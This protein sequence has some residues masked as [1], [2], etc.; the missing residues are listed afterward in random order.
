MRRWTLLV[1]LVAAALLAPAG[2]SAQPFPNQIPLPNGFAPEGIAIGRGPI[3]FTGSLAGGGIYRG[4][5]V[6]GQGQVIAESEGRTFVGMKVD[7]F[8][9]VWVAGGPAGEAYV[10]DGRTG[11]E[12]A[13]IALPT[14]EATFVNDVVVTRRAAWFT[15]SFRPAIYRVALAPNGAI[16]SVTT[17][18]LTG[19]VAFGAG[20]FNLNGIEATPS[21]R[22]L[23]TVNSFTGDLYA[24][25][26]A[27]ASVSPLDLGEATLTNGDGLV[28]AGH[29][30][31]V[32][33][34]ADN[35]VAVVALAPDLAGG[36][37]GEPI[38]A[39]SFDF[40]TTLARFGRTLYVV[41][42]RFATPVTPDTEY[43]I[44]AVSR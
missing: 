18:D 31:Y 16:G 25:D 33:R 2:V 39:E 10:F 7:A 28:L 40:P 19:Q 44:T 13:T 3:F 41:N 43:W 30:L 11:A 21:G 38:T 14:L 37:V 35:E 8:D 4:D 6:S 24:I 22:T 34:N 26:A 1:V 5:L 17:L 36:T 27:T 23:L 32:G 42:A 12:I 29:T 9:R 20:E 15:D